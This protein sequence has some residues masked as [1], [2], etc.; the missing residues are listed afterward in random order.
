MTDITLN[1]VKV[2][3]TDGTTGVDD[4]VFENAGITVGPV[5]ARELINVYGDGIESLALI[6]LLG[7]TVAE[8][9]VTSIPVENLAPGIYLL[10][11]R[12][13]KDELT[14]RVVVK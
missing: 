2:F 11:V 1:K 10:K 8:T 9:K 5:P 14:K 7:N 12:R 3:S 13:H 4:D 6:D